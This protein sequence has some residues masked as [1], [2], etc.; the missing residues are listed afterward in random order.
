MFLKPSEI[1]FSQDSVGNTFGGYTSHPFRCIGQTLDDILS[2]R[3][4]VDSIPRIS[5]MKRDGQWFTA[6]NRRLWVFQQAEKRGKIEE[7]YVSV[8][9]Y[10][11]FN[12]FTTENNGMSV[13]VRGDP[14]GNLWKRVP[15]K[16]SNEK[17]AINDVSP[18]VNRRS[19]QEKASPFFNISYTENAC[20]PERFGNGKTTS[21]IKENIATSSN[22]LSFAE[23]WKLQKDT[24]RN[25][26]YKQRD[27]R[28]LSS[29][30]QNAFPARTYSNTTIS[31]LGNDMPIRNKSQNRFDISLT[32]KS[33]SN[34]ES[35]GMS[36]TSSYFRNPEYIHKSTGGEVNISPLQ[37]ETQ[38]RCIEGVK[39]E[40]CPEVFKLFD[41]KHES[42][43][44]KTKCTNEDD[45]LSKMEKVR[46]TSREPHSDHGAIKGDVALLIDG[47]PL[48]DEIKCRIRNKKVCGGIVICITIV[49]I[50]AVVLITT[51]V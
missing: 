31:G 41:K 44:Q 24:F 12:K 8:T 34:E 7:I 42:F 23:R 9:F 2:G 45:P 28:V 27:I 40:L 43:K 21:D 17:K 13:R 51:L 37:E 25:E 36:A 30:G 32:L 20:R 16:K 35:H 39:L 10:I 22:L 18:I 33:K 49:F 46:V 6:D 14:G 1:R 26:V 38:N 4:E 48:S 3:C 47:T 15:I 50:T 11:S 29:V 19:L 5:V